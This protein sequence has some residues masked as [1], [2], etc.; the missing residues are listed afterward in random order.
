MKKY[1]YQIIRYMPD[2]FTGEYINVGIVLYAKEERFL[3][4]KTTGRYKRITAF[5][6]PANGK[7]IIKLLQNFDR[8]IRA[9]SEELNELF[10]PHDS[11]EEVT[12]SILIRDSNAVQL[13]EVRWGID[14]NL[15]AALDDL[16]HSLVEKYILSP[17]ETKTMLDID[18][19]RTKYKQYF[20]KYGVEKRLVVHEINVPK[21]VIS[22]DMSWKNE[23]WHSYEPLSFVLQEKES[24]KDKVYKWAG[25]LQGL[26]Q[27]EE[28]LH[29]T[30]MTSITDEHKDMEPFIFEY[31]KV[32]TE[33]LKVRIVSEDKAEAL[34]K[35]IKEEIDK[36]DAA[37]T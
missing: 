7:W 10:Q 5:Y 37:S 13:S 28:P 31:L 22:F 3:A 16:Y 1:Q 6:P 23:V 35:E 2:H 26:Q 36:H 12:A 8:Q 14:M 20:E 32:D 30:L 17:A 25:K 33:M 21:D 9:A 15:E 4:S 29:L 11:L 27:A 19:W 34:A 24:I 18:V